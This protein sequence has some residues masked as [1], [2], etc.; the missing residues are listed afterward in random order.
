MTQKGNTVEITVNGPF[1][2]PNG[3]IQWSS[4]DRKYVVKYDLKVQVPE[5][6][7]LR[8]KTVNDGNV[9]VR[10]VRGRLAIRNV[11]GR[12]DLERVAGSVDAQ[13]VNG[14][15]DALFTESPAE[16]SQFKTDQ[17]RR[18]PRLRGGPVRRLRAQDLERGAAQRL[19]R[20]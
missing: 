17:R 6:A 14:G 20:R 8:L 3:S 18:A 11:N 4:E 13:T 7:D 2:C 9:V 5:H 16:A 1:R 10:D 12:I 19:R 15:I